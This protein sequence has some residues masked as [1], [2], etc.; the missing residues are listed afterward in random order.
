MRGA[1][2]NATDERRQKCALMKANRPVPAPR[3]GQSSA[4]APQA[5]VMADAGCAAGPEARRWP[6]SAP[7][8]GECRLMAKVGPVSGRR[9]AVASDSAC[10]HEMQILCACDE[11]YL[12]HTATMLCSLL[13][14]N[15]VSRIHLLHGPAPKNKLAKIKHFVER[16]GSEIILYEI[17]DE[18]IQDLR[19]DRY[20]THATYYRLMAPAI[21]PKSIHK[22]LYLDSDI[23]VRNSI[24]ELWNI[25]LKD[26]ALAAVDD[27]WPYDTERFLANLEILGLPR[28]A[29]YFNAGVLLINLNHW[30]QNN[31][32][33]RAVAF[34]RENPGRVAQ[35]DQDA[36]NAILFRRWIILP[37]TW[38]GVY[39]SGWIELNLPATWNGM[40]F[41]RSGRSVPELAIVH[42][43]GE[44]KPWHWAW[45]SQEHPFAH[46]YRL[47]RRK[48]PW[49]R[50]KLEGRPGLLRRAARVVLPAGL[51]CWLRSHIARFV[52]WGKA[53]AQTSF[54]V[55]L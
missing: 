1:R 46:E 11:D 52:A 13:E 44:G 5:S 36:L 20:L 29:R 47:Y 37:A 54:L 22:I 12:P 25:D 10:T 21:L 55:E 33:E 8:S 19:I 32:C 51:E 28:D 35:H 9:V 34:I 41:G 26:Q 49:R 45:R 18:H 23:I 2:S 53:L 14:H 40:Y 24:S 15:S 38:N 48:T 50:F 42:F 6:V 16:Y 31:V 39:F 27:F 30:R 7:E 3:G 43:A 17:N 4:F